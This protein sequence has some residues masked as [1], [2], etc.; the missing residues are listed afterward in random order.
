LEPR[1][2]PEE[3]SNTVPLTLSETSPPVTEADAVVISK[4]GISEPRPS[5]E[6]TFNTIP[7][8]LSNFARSASDIQSPAEL[9]SSN[10]GTI[11]SILV[12]EADMPQ[13]IC[14]TEISGIQTEVPV[15]VTEPVVSPAEFEGPALE[16]SAALM[17]SRFE[18]TLIVSKYANT[19][20]SGIKKRERVPKIAFNCSFK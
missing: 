10:V 6:E 8:I 4:Q 7:P 17:T 11:Q 12:M 14:H 2:S 13:E 9:A 18:T 20:S 3:A 16:S 1:L 5:V 19:Q 15:T